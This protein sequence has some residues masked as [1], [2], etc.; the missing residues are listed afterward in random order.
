MGVYIDTFR[1]RCPDCSEVNPGHVYGDPEAGVY[2]WTCPVC[3]RVAE[4]DEV[5]EVED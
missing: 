1:G 2:G 3:R 5:E 4:P